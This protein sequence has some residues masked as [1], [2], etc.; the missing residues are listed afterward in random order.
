MFGIWLRSVRTVLASC[1][2]LRMENLMKENNYIN[3]NN[4]C[5]VK[6]I[7]FWKYLNATMVLTWYLLHKWHVQQQLSPSIYFFISPSR[8]GGLQ[9]DGGISL[10]P[11]RN[12]TS[13]KRKSF[14][15]QPF[16]SIYIK[17]LTTMKGEQIVR[18]VFVNCMAENELK[19]KRRQL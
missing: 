17:Y 1:I 6:I 4:T 14:A 16:Q 12:W 3:D 18:K 19:N 15:K 8:H 5:D 13:G 9:T 2:I 7:K 11:S 10:E